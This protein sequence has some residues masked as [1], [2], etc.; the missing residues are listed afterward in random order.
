MITVGFFQELFGLLTP[1]LYLYLYIEIYPNIFKIYKDMSRCGTGA[2][3]GQAGAAP[4]LLD[5]LYTLAYLYIFWIYLDRF[6]YI[7][8]MFLVYFLYISG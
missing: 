1:H 6:A 7:V 2:G 8:G 3:A 5:I 4:P